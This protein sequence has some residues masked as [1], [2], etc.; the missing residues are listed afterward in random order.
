[1]AGKRDYYEIL[2]LQK[3]ASAKDIKKAYRKLAMKYHPDRS[4]EE[5]ASDKFKEISE[6]YAVLSDEKKKAQ[7]DQ[8]GHAGFDQMYS[9][10]D[11]FRG[12]NFNDFEDIF[13]GSSPFGDIFSSMFGFGRGRRRN[14]GSDLE[15]VVRISLEEA[16]SGV[17]KEISYERNRA[18]DL[19]GGS[20]DDPKSE[21]KTCTSCQGRGQVRRVKRM[22]PMA[23]QTVVP[24]NE[25]NGRGITADK[26]C[27]E[28][29]GSGSKKV[30]EDIKADIPPGVESGMRIQLSG[31]G[32]FGPDGP[33]DLF[34][35]IIVD[36]HNKFQ[37]D[38]TDLWLDVP[39]TYTQAVLG[40]DIEVPTL[41]GKAKLKIPSGTQSH[42]VFRLRGEG[43]PY[44]NR[45]RH[46]DQMVRVLIDV[47]KNPGKKEKEL[48]KDLDSE[49][50]KKKKGLFE[51][52]F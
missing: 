29:S 40:D 7:Y 33:G 27:P 30:H 19:C 22:G 35:R 37:R 42:T 21:K 25:C 51:S 41:E 2:G 46:G 9:Q 1:M 45:N 36:E 47:P 8:Y 44:I 4:K 28:C 34:V 12:A 14:V 43:M 17:K 31:M 49:Y 10:E 38:G 48:L 13:G 20:G 24:C 15:A 18:C 23:F 5:G 16:Y 52:L 50:A 26:K 32:E 3:D 39:I 6:A 11:I